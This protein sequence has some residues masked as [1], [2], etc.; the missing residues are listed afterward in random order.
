MIHKGPLNRS[1][2]EQEA[3]MQ[4]WCICT[5]ACAQHW[6][7]SL[8]EWYT[9]PKANKSVITCPGSLWQSLCWWQLC[10][11]EEGR[12]TLTFQ[13]ALPWSSRGHLG[14][15]ATILPVIKLLIKLRCPNLLLISQSLRAVV[16]LRAAIASQS[17]I[18][19]EEHK[20]EILPW[21][22]ND[23][24]KPQIELHSDP[25]FYTFSGLRLDKNTWLVKQY[26]GNDFV[27]HTLPLRE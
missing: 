27:I 3:L 14:W 9:L 2:S 13:L 12:I 17:A 4:V 18:M 8:N 23:T 10:G 1:K 20:I 11:N 22:C 19:T 21:I 6:D 25:T 16:S 24:R 15:N 26:P 7:D 5:V